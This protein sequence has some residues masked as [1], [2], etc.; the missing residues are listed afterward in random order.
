MSFPIFLSITGLC[1]R[2]SIK[3]TA[4]YLWRKKNNFPSPITPENCNPRW[5]LSD[6]EK[7]EAANVKNIITVESGVSYA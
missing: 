1:T 5:R 7:W 4:C 2:Y 6:I 3:R